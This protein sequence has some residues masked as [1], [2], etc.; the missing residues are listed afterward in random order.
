[1][2]SANAPNLAGV[3]VPRDTHH[4]LVLRAERRFRYLRPAGDALDGGAEAAEAHELNPVAVEF[5][6]RGDVP[7]ERK[8]VKRAH[9]TAGHTRSAA[10]NNADRR[11]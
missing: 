1:L 7:G 2:S 8:N 6:G 4:D 5:K 3:H 9:R 11:T 10:H